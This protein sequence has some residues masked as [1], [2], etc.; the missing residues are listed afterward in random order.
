MFAVCSFAKA[1]L[2][3]QFAPCLA[4]Q[5]DF[6]G[7]HKCAFDASVSIHLLIVFVLVPGI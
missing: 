1:L 4:F 7:K 5:V 6:K 2:D 3:K